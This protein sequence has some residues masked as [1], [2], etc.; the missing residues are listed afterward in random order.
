MIRLLIFLLAAGFGDTRNP[1]NASLPIW[2]HIMLP[3]DDINF[4]A[5]TAVTKS[6][7]LIAKGIFCV[8]Y[9]QN[10]RGVYCICHRPYPDP[11]DPVPDEM[12]QESAQYYYFPV[13]FQH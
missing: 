11:E 13:I 1:S 9:N 3:S 4:L 6:S 10:F 7:L 2:L 5:V 12:I 8:R